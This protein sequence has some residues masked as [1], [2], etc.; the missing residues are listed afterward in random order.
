MN[1]RNVRPEIADV[2]PDVA[3][4][5]PE[6]ADALLKVFQTTRRISP[7]ANPDGAQAIV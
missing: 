2:H 4:V 6:I 5:H 3:D 1:V 7:P